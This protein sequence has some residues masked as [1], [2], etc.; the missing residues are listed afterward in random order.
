MGQVTILG[1][2]VAIE[3]SIAGGDTRPLLGGV[4]AMADLINARGPWLQDYADAYRGMNKIVFFR[5][6]VQVNGYDMS[7]PCCD[8]D[9]RIFYWET[10]EFLRNMDADVHANTFFHDCWHVVQFNRDGGFAKSD[11]ERVSREVDAINQQIAVARQLGCDDREVN[12]LV[13]FRN[14]Q[15]KLKD[16]LAEGV[17]LRRD[18]A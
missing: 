14:D 4:Q 7:R 12:F 13:A 9:D 18:S 15:Q 1:H 11:D 8:E 2:D 5:G 17:H 10:D 16:R 3:F 6:T